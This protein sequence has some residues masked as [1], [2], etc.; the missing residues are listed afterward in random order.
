[1]VLRSQVAAPLSRRSQQGRI[2]PQVE[3]R[4]LLSRARRGPRP[5]LRQPSLSRLRP[6]SRGQ[7]DRSLEYRLL[8]PRRRFFEGQGQDHSQSSAQ[9]RFA[10]LLGAYQSHRD[11]FLADRADGSDQLQ[12]LE[13]GKVIFWP[14]RM[15]GGSPGN[16]NSRFVQLSVQR[17][18]N[19]VVTPLCQGSKQ[20]E[21]ASSGLIFLLPSNT[22]STAIEPLTSAV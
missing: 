2:G 3:A 8:R 7:C 1:M 18:A 4:R 5:L 16:L 6:Q 22:V 19:L 14:R 20:F 21:F 12:T 15:K 17:G 10:H 11:L 13:R 9:T